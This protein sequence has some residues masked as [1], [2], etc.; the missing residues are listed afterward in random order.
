MGMAVGLRECIKTVY[1][2]RVRVLIFDDMCFFLL[3]WLLF[4]LEVHIWPGLDFQGRLI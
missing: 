2:K 3:Q 1:Y 4:I